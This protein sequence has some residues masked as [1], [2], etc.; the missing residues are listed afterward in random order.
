MD[1]VG[2][3]DRRF[4]GGFSPPGPRGGARSAAG[5]TGRDYLDALQFVAGFG[6][7]V[8]VL[9]LLQRA[10]IQLLGVLRV[11]LHRFE[12]TD[13]ALQVVFGEAVQRVRPRR[14]GFDHRGDVR[15]LFAQELLFLSG[16]RCSARWWSSFVGA[17]PEAVEQPADSLEQTTGWSLGGGCRGRSVSCRSPFFEDA[18]QIGTMTRARS[19]LRL[20]YS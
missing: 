4:G 11:L 7:V 17:G 6:F 1:V 3:A 16:F 5:R 20:A 13:Q 15:G 10:Q 12:L 8:A 14:G 2:H 9:E 18:L 19:H